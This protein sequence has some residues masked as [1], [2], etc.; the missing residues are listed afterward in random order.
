MRE[1]FLFFCFVYVL[2]LF[3]CNLLQ[4]S[5][6]H[7]Y[8]FQLVL[9]RE[10]ITQVEGVNQVNIQVKPLMPLCKTTKERSVSL[11][12]TTQNKRYKW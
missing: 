3:L 1:D 4:S 10:M 8:V 11:S 7:P 12:C 6:P 5:I 9:I 2:Y